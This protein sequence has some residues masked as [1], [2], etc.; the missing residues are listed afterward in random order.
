[1]NDKQKDKCQQLM[2]LYTIR[3]GN[4]FICYM[5]ETMSSCSL[6]MVLPI[7]QYSPK[8]PILSASVSV[9][10]TLLYSSRIQTTC[11]RKH[12]EASQDSYLAKTFLVFWKKI[13]FWQWL[14]ECSIVLT[15]TS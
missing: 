1:M 14:I 7:Y 12:N 13:H 11:A 6:E 4:K 9:D 10:K 2:N 15:L 3:K 5:A 8:Q